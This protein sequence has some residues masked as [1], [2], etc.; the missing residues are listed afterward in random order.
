MTLPSFLAASIS[1]GVT[2]SGG[3]AS[4][5][6]RVDNAAPASKTPEPFSTSR[7]DIL[8]FFI[9]AIHPLFRR[10]FY[11][12]SY[13]LFLLFTASSFVD[14]ALSLQLDLITGFGNNQSNIT[15]PEFGRLK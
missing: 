9:E 11:T 8:G 13:V 7:R 6:T 14:S 2:G 12:R 10:D 5:M 15:R 4:A 3:G 1:A